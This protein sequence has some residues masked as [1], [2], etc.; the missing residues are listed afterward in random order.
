[1][2]IRNSPAQMKKCYGYLFGNG[3]PANFVGAPY[4]ELHFLDAPQESATVL[5]ILSLVNTH[6]CC[7]LE[8]EAGQTLGRCLGRKSA[9]ALR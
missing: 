8:E 1:M 4:S 9:T 5:A 2:G 3:Q 6:A 7:C